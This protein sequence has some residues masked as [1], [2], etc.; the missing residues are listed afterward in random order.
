MG[1]NTEIKIIELSPKRWKEYKDLRIDA[2]VKSGEAFGLTVKE[3]KDQKNSFWKKNLINSEKNDKAFF[4]FA[5]ANKK[6]IGMIGAHQGEIE[7]TKHNA[8]IVNVYIDKKFRGNRL[9]EK[10]FNQ[11]LNKI[12]KNRLINRLDLEVTPSQLSAISLYKKLGFKESGVFHNQLKYK[13]K[14]YDQLYME[15]LLK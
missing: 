2:L 6:I 9:S 13:G 3:G 15:M 4:I 5:E 12:K 7:K 10:L 11:L 1:K 14:Y 8:T